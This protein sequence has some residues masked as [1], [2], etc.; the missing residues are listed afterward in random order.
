M[1]DVWHY[2]VSAEWLHFLLAGM[3]I[4]FVGSLDAPTKDS[5]QW[6][7][8]LFAVLNFLALQFSRMTPKVENSP[9]WQA[10]FNNGQATAFK[11]GQTK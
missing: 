5:P 4:T 1:S 6:Y 10:A 11:N 2:L 8:S 3:Y 7:V 9:N